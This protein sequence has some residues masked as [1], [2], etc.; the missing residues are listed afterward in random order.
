MNKQPLIRALFLFCEHEGMDHADSVIDFYERFKPD[1]IIPE[2]AF[3]FAPEFPDRHAVNKDIPK[4]VE[5]STRDGPKPFL[6]KIIEYA[7]R[8]NIEMRCLEEQFNQ[9]E[10]MTV[11]K[12]TQYDMSLLDTIPAKE[13]QKHIEDVF[14][15]AMILSPYKTCADLCAYFNWARES[16]IVANFFSQEFK[17]LIGE[18]L[19]AKNQDEI[20]IGFTY[21]NWHEQMSIDFAKR[22]R[23]E[24]GFFGNVETH[25]IIFHNSRLYANMKL[26]QLIDLDST[27]SYRFQHPLLRQERIKFC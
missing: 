9:E 3:P 2:L 4:Y 22:S 20:R 15:M 1:I 6:K 21:G 7:T 18:K 23:Q 11:L 5:L 13:R 19:E 8:N 24:K 16:K 25:K 17:E 12:I 14:H 10:K 26:R 27:K